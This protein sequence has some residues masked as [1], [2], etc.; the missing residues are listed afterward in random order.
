MWE[1]LMVGAVFL[2]DWG[3]SHSSSAC[4][5]L[6]LYSWPVAYGS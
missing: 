4:V 1:A 5:S 2:G 6:C 3:V